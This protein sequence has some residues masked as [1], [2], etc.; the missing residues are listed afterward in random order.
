MDACETFG[1]QRVL[2]FEET[3]R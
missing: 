1:K 2:F 3:I